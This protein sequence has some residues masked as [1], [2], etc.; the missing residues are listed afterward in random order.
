MGLKMTDRWELMA[1]QT[2]KLGEHWQVIE[3]QLTFPPKGF[4]W[5]IRDSLSPI[6]F[7]FWC[8]VRDNAIEAWLANLICPNCSEEIGE[9]EG[10]PHCSECRRDLPFRSSALWCEVYTKRNEP[11]NKEQ[12]FLRLSEALSEF[13]RDETFVFILLQETLTA[14]ED[15][16]ERA[17]AHLEANPAPKR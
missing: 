4:S 3:E 8:N 12:V 11:P 9:K 1:E 10:R 17:T 7:E 14:V 2:Y 16:M 6:A 15:F 13:Y 5:R